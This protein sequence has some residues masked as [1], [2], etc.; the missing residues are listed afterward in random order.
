MTQS[1]LPFHA[2]RL[3]LAGFLTGSACLCLSVPAAMAASPAKTDPMIKAAIE[4]TAE[5]PAPM[6][7][8]EPETVDVQQLLQSDEQQPDMTQSAAVE[9]KSAFRV[10]PSLTLQERYDDNIFAENTNT[11]DDYVTTITPAVEIGWEGDQSHAVLNAE[12]SYNHYADHDDLEHHDFTLAT[13]GAIGINS[14]L[15]IPFAASIAQTHEDYADDLTRQ[16]AKTPIK[17]QTIDT[18]AGLKFKP[19]RF[20]LELGGQY[21]QDEFDDETDLAGTTQIIRSDADRETHLGF[22]GLDFD[23]SES[24][25]LIAKGE[26]GTRDYDSNNYQ[27]GSYSGPQRDSDIWN[28][29]A[30]FRFAPSKQLS[31][32]FLVGY[33]SY[34]Y[35]D[36]T[37]SDADDMIGTLRITWNATQDTTI[38]FLAARKM[39]ED[40]ELVNAITQ[41]SAGLSLSHALGD[42]W[43]VGA[44]G[45]YALLEFEGLS[46]EDTIYSGG[47]SLDYQIN[48]NF[49]LGAAY[50]YSTRD[51]DTNTLEY[52]RNQV[53]LRAK[54]Q[55]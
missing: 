50:E 32:E 21:I 24:V 51:S 39:F 40:D 12:Y 30:G 35:D 7:A 43:V 33:Q 48:D 20:G 16:I 37:L 5:T 8:A 11:N 49:T 9:T 14:A 18:K 36:V 27:S 31:G 6:P 41:D 46:R 3:L 26:Y 4:E 25:T 47:L 53:M 13:Q 44:D 2:S 34:D 15:S 19:G 55:L 29:L 22:L 38:G 54:G 45:Q 52:D 23:V 1:L 10:T 28:A 17:Q 42:H